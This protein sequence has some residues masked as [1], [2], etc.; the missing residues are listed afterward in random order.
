MAH[1]QECIVIGAKKACHRVFELRWQVAYKTLAL[2]Q[3]QDVQAT[4]VASCLRVILVAPYLR[5]I[6]TRSQ[7][8][9]LAG[10]TLL[11]LWDASLMT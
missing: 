9:E 7:G 5:A 2:Y 11:A 1:S 4:L 10:S 8:P 3:R 6:S